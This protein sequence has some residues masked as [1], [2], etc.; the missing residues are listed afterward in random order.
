MANR[1]SSFLRK[2]T[3]HVSIFIANS[4][5]YAGKSG[6]FFEFYIRHFTELNGNFIFVIMMRLSKIFCCL[7]A[8]TVLFA[9]CGQNANQKMIT[10]KADSLFIRVRCMKTVSELIEG[11]LL[12]PTQKKLQYKIDY[13]NE[14]YPDTI[15]KMQAEKLIQIKDAEQNYDSLILTTKELQ[16]Q[17]AIQLE[18]VIKLNSEIGKGKNENILQ[19]LTFESKC[20]DSLNLVLDLIIKRSIE[21]SCKSQTFN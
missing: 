7:L 16:K 10:A 1:E 13:I 3:P 2:F 19:Y 20:A 17:S 15:S 9:G 14:T 11:N 12:I 4:G 6:L 18:Q 21:L 8:F 5:C